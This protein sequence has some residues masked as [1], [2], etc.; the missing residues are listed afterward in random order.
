MNE[1]AISI[2]VDYIEHTLG[3]ID[4]IWPEH[5]FEYRSDERWAANE[6]L[7]RVLDNPFDDPAIII[8]EYLFEM[9]CFEHI[10]SIDRKRKMFSTA[11]DTAEKLLIKVRE[12]DS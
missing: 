9:L 1:K 6:I 11:K 4:S 8:E 12:G 2:I 7:E 3:A 10:T 5:M